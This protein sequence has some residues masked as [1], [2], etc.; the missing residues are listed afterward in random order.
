MKATMLLCDYAEELAGKL[1]MMGAGWD[2]VVVG[3]PF[4][5]AL[6]VVLGV[7]WDQTNQTLDLRAALVDQDG[8]R[9][10]NEQEEPIEITGKFEVGRPAGTPHGSEL[11]LPFVVRFSQVVLEPGLYSF[12]LEVG[13]DEVARATF[14]AVGGGA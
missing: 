3:Q 1:Y 11:H 9:V 5:V 12:K 13:P 10:L 14:H 8:L 6:A 7:P 4:N 2:R